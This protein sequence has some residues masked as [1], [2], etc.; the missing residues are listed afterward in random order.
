[1]GNKSWLGAGLLRLEEGDGQAGG[2]A[3]DGGGW[4]GK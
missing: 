1:M 2:G 3:F 4:H